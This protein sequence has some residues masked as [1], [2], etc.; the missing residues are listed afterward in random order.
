[1][2]AGA[3]PV[4]GLHRDAQVQP[5]PVVAHDGGRARR[6][7][8]SSSRSA[9][10]RCTGAP[11]TASPRTGA[12][13]SSA[14]RPRTSSGC[15]ASSTGSRRPPTPAEFM[16]TLKID[17]EQ[18]EV[19][20]FTPKGKVDHA[21]RPA[22]R[23]STSRT[24]STPRSATVAS[25]HGSTGG[26]S[27]STPTLASGDTVEIF[28][29]KVEGAGPSRDWLQ[30]VHTP[31]AASKIRQWF[32]RERRVDAIDT[33][34][35]ELVKALRREGLPVQ[36]LAQSDALDDGRRRAELRRPR[37]AARRD[38]RGPRVGQGG[39]AAGPDGSCAAARSSCRSPPRARRERPRR[40]ARR[41]A[42]V[43]V[44]GLDDVMVR[45]SRCCTPGAGRRDH[46]LRHPGPRRLGAPH[47]LRQRRRP[48]RAR[49]SGSSRSSGTTT[50][51]RTFVVSVEIEALD[52]SRLLRDVAAGALR[53]PR[54][55][56]VVHVADVQRPGREVPL[57]LRAR[58]PR[59]TSTR[60]SRR[61]SASTRSTRRPG[62]SPVTRAPAP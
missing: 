40:D 29:S 32:S 38:R 41:A 36:K 55:H 59:A 21:R 39:R 51:R 52:R 28:T 34:R 12:T 61:S 6:A 58:R 44:E 43:H 23:R 50:S 48:R 60:S 18:D 54:E 35:D 2:A 3:G 20:V 45:L 15:S 53:A 31:A 42:G 46:G 1:M 5:L 26:W 33:G 22:R 13:R 8:R 57:R 19:F 49:P 14:A 30:F 47:R 9:R 37:G 24:R 27:R 4:Q 56:P 62:C 17:L 10:R 25:A 11:S 16:E 7:R